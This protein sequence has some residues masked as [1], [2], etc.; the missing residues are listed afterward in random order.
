VTIEGAAAPA[1]RTRAARRA[2]VGRRLG[3]PLTYAALVGLAVLFMSPF[4]W[5][6]STSLKET[7]EIYSS[8]PTLLPRSPQWTTYLRVW[9]LAPFARWVLN[10]VV[11]VVASTLGTVLTASLVAYSLG[12]F[13]YRGR[14]VLFAVTLGTMMLPAQVT[15]IPQYVLFHRLGWVN[16]SLPLWVP[17]WFGGSAF[18]IFLMRQFIRTLPRQLDEAAVID[19]AGFVRIYWS[20]LMPLC[21]PALTTLTIFSAIEHWNDFLGPLVYLNSPDKFT[22]AL[23]LNAF[24][25]VSDMKYPQ[26]YLLMAASVMTIIPAIVVFFCSQRYFM[27]GIVLSGVKN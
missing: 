26:E 15:L 22:V 4:L 2:R 5:A 7:S 3:R 8:P 18:F 12:R 24:Q 19:G 17:A 25:A 9:E 13:R 1:V 23:G 10:S 16:T 27:E 21:R 14:D 11:I 6:I 20:I